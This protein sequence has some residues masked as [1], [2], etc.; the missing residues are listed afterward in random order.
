MSY[1]VEPFLTAPAR[2]PPCTRLPVHRPRTTVGIHTQVV[3]QV[4][5]GRFVELGQQRLQGPPACSSWRESTGCSPYSHGDSI[6]LVLRQPTAVPPA[7]NLTPRLAL[8]C[9]STCTTGYGFFAAS[10][11]RQLVPRPFCKGSRYGRPLYRRMGPPARRNGW[12]LGTWPRG[13]SRCRIYFSGASA[14]PRP[15]MAAEQPRPYAPH[16]IRREPGTPGTGKGGISPR[17]VLGGYWLGGSPS[18]ISHSQLAISAVGLTRN[19]PRS[20]SFGRQFYS[21]RNPR[22]QRKTAHNRHKRRLSCRATWARRRSILP[23]DSATNARGHF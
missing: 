17:R 20:L 19:L 7:L 23:E 10:D 13:G 18:N 9:R 2:E 6:S 22:V 14:K 21:T 11:S 15:T 12:P 3:W 4:V 16:C 1:P 8:H 5:E